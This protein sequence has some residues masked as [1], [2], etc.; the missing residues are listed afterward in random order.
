MCDGADAAFVARNIYDYCVA[1]LQSHKQ[2]I[3]QAEQKIKDENAA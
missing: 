1:E 3:E 2:E